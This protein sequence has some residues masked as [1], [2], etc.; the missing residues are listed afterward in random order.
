MPRRVNPRKRGGAYGAGF[1]DGIVSA[2]KK[3]IPFVRDNKLISKG[4]NALGFK[5]VGNIASSLG[6]GKRRRRRPARKGGMVMRALK[7]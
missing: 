6:F 5:N 3:A 4:A 7:I 1:F 2:V